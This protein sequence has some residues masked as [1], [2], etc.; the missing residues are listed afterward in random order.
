MH[1]DRAWL[2]DVAAKYVPG[3]PDVTDY[4]T[5]AAAAARHADTVLDVPVYTTSQHRAAALFHQLINVPGLDWAN[6]QYAAAVA[7]AYLQISGEQVSVEPYRVAQFA[8]RAQVERLP[9][10]EVAVE[11]KNWCGS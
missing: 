4:G 10:R 2:L 6:E 7:L 8:Q 11:I 9:V 5:F 3:D 1:V